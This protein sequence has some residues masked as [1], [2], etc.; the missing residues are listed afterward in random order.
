[1]K[2]LIIG[3]TAAT[4]SGGKDKGCLFELKTTISSPK[5]FMSSKLQL[6]IEEYSRIPPFF[7]ICRGLVQK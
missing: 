1:M 7:F 6:L 4:N 5:L 3:I 2:T